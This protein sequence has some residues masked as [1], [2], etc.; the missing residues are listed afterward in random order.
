MIDILIVEDH[1]EIASLLSDF[2]R[3]EGYT[4]STAE[5]GGKALHLYETYGAPSPNSIIV[6]GIDKE[7][8]GQ[9]CAEIREV[10]PPEPYKGKGIK[11]DGEHIIRKEGKMGKK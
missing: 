1:K 8:V 2:L 4:V 5:T 6:K 7:A 10:R 11:Y 9:L 3:K